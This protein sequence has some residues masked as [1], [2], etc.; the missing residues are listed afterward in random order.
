MIDDN[1]IIIS[2]QISNISNEDLFKSIIFA[3]GNLVD[4]IPNLLEIRE[5]KNLFIVDSEARAQEVNLH[6][7]IISDISENN[8]TFLNYFKNEITSG[9]HIR[10]GNAIDSATDVMF[11]SFCKIQ[12][13]TSN[14]SN[15]IKQNVLSLNED[16]FIEL[17]RITD[18]L[19]IGLISHSE[20][21]SQIHSIFPDISDNILN[22]A[23]NFIPPYSSQLACLA[24][25]L[26]IEV[27]VVGYIALALGAH[28]VVGARYA[29]VYAVHFQK[30]TPYNISQKLIDDI[31]AYFN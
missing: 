31:V 14:Q 16:D 18:E 2:A 24:L 29:V 27:V 3:E 1:S 15:Q 17:Q 10:V 28:T 25:V 20:A 7:A 5:L 8:A 23:G 21:L 30:M 13:L 4:D 6:N 9:N 12:G 11:Y 19:N 22:D 26:A